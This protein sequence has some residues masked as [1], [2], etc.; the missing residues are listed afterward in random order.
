MNRLDAVK[1]CPN[2][3]LIIYRPYEDMSEKDTEYMK[4]R[5]M[6]SRKIA[7]RTLLF[8][9]KTLTLESNFIKFIYG[10]KRNNKKIF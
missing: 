7:E 2:I 4:I 5:H 6:E 3:E 10:Y 8:H 1:E 9:H